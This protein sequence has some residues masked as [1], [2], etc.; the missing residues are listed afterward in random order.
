M[1]LWRPADVSTEAAE[2]EHNQKMTEPGITTSNNIFRTPSGQIKEASVTVGEDYD[3]ST[4]AGGE[5]QDQEM[6]EPSLV[7]TNNISSTSS[8]QTEKASTYIR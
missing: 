3:I 2:E 5:K 6:T 1:T 4:E 7:M 8:G